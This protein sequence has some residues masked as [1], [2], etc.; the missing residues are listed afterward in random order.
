ML[1]YQILVVDDD[2][3]AL[4]GLLALL[5]DAGHQSTGAATFD[6]ARRLLDVGHYDL[7]VADVRLRSYN[8]LH[9]VRLSRLLHPEMGIILM[10]G[11]PERSLEFEASRYGAIYMEKP[12]DP[13]QFMRSVDRLLAQVRRERRWPRHHAPETFIVQIGNWRARLLDVSYGGLRFEMMAP[14]TPLP[15]TVAVRMPTLNLYVEAETIWT[16]RLSAPGSL[17]GGLALLSEGADAPLPWRAL[18]DSLGEESH[19][20]QT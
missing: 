14:E 3:A 5:R 10:T 15:P 7:L 17:R 9:L 8:G 12:I 20:I 13:K 6:A 2:E 1:P 4:A 11:Y 19:D 18:V 16:D